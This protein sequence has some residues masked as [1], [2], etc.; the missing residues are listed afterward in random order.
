[1]GQAPRSYAKSLQTTDSHS[2]PVPFFHSLGANHDNIT[3]E[4]YAE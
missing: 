3:P 1:M 4:R 2:E